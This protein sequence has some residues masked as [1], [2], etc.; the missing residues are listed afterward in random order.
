MYKIDILCQ[1][2]RIS[3]QTFYR[4]TKTNKDFRELVEKNREKKGSSYR[5]GEPV[6]S[7]LLDYSGIQDKS[8]QEQQ[9]S[10]QQQQSQGATE[11]AVERPETAPPPPEASTREKELLDRIE[12]LEREIDGLRAALNDK[13]Q[14]RKALFYQN[15]QLVRILG[16]EK[17]EKQALLPAPGSTAPATYPAA[18]PA[19]TS[20]VERVKSLFGKKSQQPQPVPADAIQV[21]TIQEQRDEEQP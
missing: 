7:W 20:F 15:I 9:P 21:E 17:D 4:L 6:L 10:Q 8:N 2:A 19:K 16:Q 3:Q 13:E 12:A 5:Y 11:Q 18:A 14:E 1:K